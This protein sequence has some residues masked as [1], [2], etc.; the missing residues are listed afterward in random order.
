MGSSRSKHLDFWSLLLLL[1]PGCSW[2][3]PWNRNPLAQGFLCESFS[4]SDGQAGLWPC[5]FLLLSGAYSPPPTVTSSWS[6]WDATATWSQE[7]SPLP[8]ASFFTL[9]SPGALAG[10]L[11]SNWI[12]RPARAQDRV[13]TCHVPPWT[14]VETGVSVWLLALGNSWKFS[15]LFH[16]PSNLLF[17][18][19]ALF[20]ASNILGSLIE[21]GL[22]NSPRF[23][24]KNRHKEQLICLRVPN[25]WE[26]L[27]WL[28]W[29]QGL[30][31][32][33]FR[34]NVH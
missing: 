13:W 19:L 7:G 17:S 6:P 20:Y 15:L 3:F 10:R 8:Y 34:D 27:T 22:I 11:L 2:R 33:Q 28:A 5:T 12:R 31:S 21:P 14:P 1:T 23:K 25:N 29:Y 9:T 18:G 30:A 32:E 24:W 26:N 16:Q 4:Y